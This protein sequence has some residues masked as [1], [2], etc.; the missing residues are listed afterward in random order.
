MQN[1]PKKLEQQLKDH[2]AVGSLDLDTK[3]VS[4]D[5]TIKRAYQLADGKLMESVL[6]PYHDGRYTACISSQ[7]RCAQGCVFCATGHMV[8]FL[9]IGAG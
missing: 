5:G 2:A 8:F 3:L 1:I 9:T 7:A 6:M 4:K